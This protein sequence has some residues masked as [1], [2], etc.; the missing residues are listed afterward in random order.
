MLDHHWSSLTCASFFQKD[1]R[2][3]KRNKTYRTV[4]GISPVDLFSF[5]HICIPT[6]FH[7]VFMF[8]SSPNRTPASVS[9]RQQQQQ[10]QYQHRRLQT[11]PQTQHSVLSSR[12]GSERKQCNK[13]ASLKYNRNTAARFIPIATTDGWTHTM[14]EPSYSHIPVKVVFVMGGGGL[15]MGDLLEWREKTKTHWLST[16]KS[17]II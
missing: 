12:S 1:T 14:T 8:S 17:S 7:I 15:H 9:Q 16:W 5:S 13:Q 4:T 11:P 10:Q 2:V 3:G 6:V